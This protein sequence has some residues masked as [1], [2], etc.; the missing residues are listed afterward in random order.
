[1][2]MKY[3]RKISLVFLLGISIVTVT[4]AA[5]AEE[6]A[7]IGHRT[8]YSKIWEWKT[9]KP[10]KTKFVEHSMQRAG[11]SYELSPR[12]AWPKPGSIQ[13]YWVGGGASFGHG[14]APLAEEGTWGWDKTGTSLLPRSLRLGYSHGRL[15]QGGTGSY[16]TDRVKK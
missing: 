8:L 3:N 13:G 14:H 7:E 11:N 16:A 9:Y 10:G 4:L 6:P 2:T 12:A 5:R 1:M 15:F